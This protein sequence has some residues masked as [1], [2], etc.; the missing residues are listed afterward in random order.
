MLDLLPATAGLFKD[1]GVQG[2][3]GVSLNWLVQQCV[4]EVDLSRG[5]AF[6]YLVVRGRPSCSIQVLRPFT[7]AVVRYKGVHSCCTAERRSN[8]LA[9]LGL[10]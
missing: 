10:T 6:Y 7:V 3:G 4:K 8:D 2:K 5:R 1:V 9:A